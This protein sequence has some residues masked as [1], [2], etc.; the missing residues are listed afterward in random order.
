SHLTLTR[1]AHH[2]IAAYARPRLAGVRL[3][4]RIAVIAGRAVR[5]RSRR[6]T[7]ARGRA[8]RRGNLTLT[9]RAHHRIA[10][11]AHPG[12][13]RVSL[14]ARIAVIARRTVR[15]RSRGAPH[16]RPGIARASHLTLTRRAHHRI[17]AY[18]HPGLA[19]VR[20][21]A[22]IAVIAGRAVRL[23]SRRATH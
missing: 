12:L 1:R 13:D 19:R 16:S 11:H 20:L 9:R 7:H 10:A 22:R 23:R 5:L 15:L 21:R 18:A 6:A 3:R 4:A 2:R 8:S 17:A 14:R